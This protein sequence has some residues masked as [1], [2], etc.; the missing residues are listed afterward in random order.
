MILYIF[1][2]EV[3]LKT[4]NKQTDSNRLTCLMLLKVQYFLFTMQL[5]Q[6]LGEVKIEHLIMIIRTCHG[7]QHLSWH[8]T[9]NA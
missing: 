4:V 2:I 7:Q 9:Q 8:H 3:S 1:V 5:F 6:P